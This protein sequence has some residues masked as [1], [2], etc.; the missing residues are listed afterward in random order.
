[1]H[2]LF[3]PIPG[4][5]HSYPMVPLAWAMRAAGHTVDYLA[6]ID[7]LEIRNAGLPVVDPLP[8]RTMEDMLPEF[9]Q[10]GPEIFESMAHLSTEEILGLKPMVV[11]PWD[12]PV[13]V[14]SYVEAAKRIKPDLIVFDPVF[15]AG[16]IAAA[17]LGVPA[18]GHG[19]MLVRFTP[20]FLHEHAADGFR[21]HGVGLP[22]RS[23][24]LDVG[25]GSLIEPGPS[26]W[27]MRYVPYN[28]GG[29]LPGWLGEPAERP[30]V[31]V[32]LGTVSPRTSGT[33]RFVRVLEAAAEIDAEFAL[34][35]SPATAEALGP[36]P[37][38]VR[39]TGW[40]PLYQLL[41]TCSA[42]VHHGGAGT[43]YTAIAAGIPQLTIPQGADNDYNGRA[44]QAYGCGLLSSGTEIDAEQITRLLTDDGLRSAAQKLKA[45]NDELPPP[46]AVAD[47]I[48][49]FAG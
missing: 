24:L 5:G 45:E 3:M 28:G 25:P 38:N 40:V 36:L 29:V 41:Q 1:M 13:F 18:V 43:M 42:I 39:V 20:E 14:D 19:Y 49:R 6:A 21:R 23:A 33:G 7:G 32:T 37:G 22:E 15:N 9:I 27:Q 12:S 34:T 4:I 2:V 31:A 48:I 46:S 44:L 26:R 11:R 47:D 17:S 30:R 10:Q 8:G 16:L 35:V